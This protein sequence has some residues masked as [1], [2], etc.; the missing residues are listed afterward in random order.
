MAVPR[1][2]DPGGTDRKP[3]ARR[4]ALENAPPGRAAGIPG[5]GHYRP[6]NRAFFTFFAT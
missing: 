2:M 3:P 4:A 1:N 5:N 6:Q